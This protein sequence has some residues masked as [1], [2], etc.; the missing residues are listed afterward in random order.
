MICGMI[1][2]D[3]K[4]THLES[5]SSAVSEDL[6]VPWSSDVPFMPGGCLDAGFLYN[7]VLMRMVDVIG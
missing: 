4:R 5:V 6:R 2:Y 1:G 3:G 7:F